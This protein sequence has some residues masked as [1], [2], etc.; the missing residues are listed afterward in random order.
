MNTTSS[1]AATRRPA[2]SERRFASRSGFP[3]LG[4][5]LA[6]VV[7][8]IVAFTRVERPHGE[9]VRV[10]AL[11]GG[12]GGLLVAFGLV[13]PGFFVVN[14]NESRVLV[15]FGTYRGTERRAG[16]WWTNPFTS[17]RKVS[18]RARTLN[19]KTLKVND[20]AGNPIEIGA[21]VVWQVQDTAQA[22]FDVDRYEEFVE[23]QSEAA[24]RDLAS[25]HPYDDG[26]APGQGTSLRGSRDQIAVEMGHALDERLSRAGVEV[27]EARISHLAYAPEIAS[28]ML[29]RQQAA[30]VIAARSLIVEGAVGMVEH[31]LDLLAQKKVLDLDPERRAQMVQNLL[32]VLCSH[33]NPTPVI[34]AGTVYG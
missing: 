20:L 23:T 28:A 14:P 22:L 18:L 16:F 19:G 11:L 10:L 24:V 6:L 7:G 34:N 33:S 13:V 9:G 27:V 25:R 21:V 12:I 2:A 31:A 8:S 5:L 26:Q 15:L 29:Q 4:L 3:M 30:A 32:V 17:K 1:P